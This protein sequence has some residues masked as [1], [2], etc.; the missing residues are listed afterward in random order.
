MTKIVIYSKANCPYCEYAKKY[1][2]S[3]NLAFT[4]IRIDL[5]AQ[6]LLEMEQLT[7]RRTVPQIFINDQLIGGYE[8]MMALSKSGEL[9][10]I[11]A[12]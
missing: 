3:K 7:K 4:E 5:D 12:Q 10:K 6:K 2:V 11:L 8:D 9:Q 1:F